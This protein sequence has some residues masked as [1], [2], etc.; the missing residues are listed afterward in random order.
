[1]ES[2]LAQAAR[3]IPILA[4]RYADLNAFRKEVL[5]AI[6]KHCDLPVE[7]ASQPF[8]ALERDAQAG[9][10]LA[11]E[12]PEEGNKLELTDE[13]KQEI[14]RILAQYPVIKQSDFA[15]PNTLKL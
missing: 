4:V 1:M 15:V 12:N 11:R 2:Y 10:V 3:G 13:Q 8:K 7:R 9:T 5:A 6:F 14:A